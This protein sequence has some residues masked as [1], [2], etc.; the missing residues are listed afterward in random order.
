MPSQQVVRDGEGLFG[1]VEYNK[2]H[3]A[4]VIYIAA[5]D[6]AF[7]DNEHGDSVIKPCMEV[8]LVHELLHCVLHEDEDEQAVERIARAL[9]IAR[10]G[11]DITFFDGS[12]ICIE[13]D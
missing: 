11:L 13:A 4:A 8:T 6:E 1:R 12:K 5:Y 10:Y 2:G 3:R 9:L 7:V